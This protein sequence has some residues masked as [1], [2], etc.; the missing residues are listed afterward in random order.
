M[1]ITARCFASLR[2]LAAARVE[3]ELPDG[4][5]VADAWADL[6]ARF[7]AVYQF[8]LN[9]WSWDE[10]Y[11]RFIIQPSKDLAMFLWE[12]DQL[13][14]LLRQGSTWQLAV[15]LPQPPG[16]NFTGVLAKARDA[17]ERG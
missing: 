14:R 4:S 15:V 11:D 2:E 17:H 5:A 6:A 3:L 9:K 13:S 10:I 12:N 7:P 1:R 16:V 8:L